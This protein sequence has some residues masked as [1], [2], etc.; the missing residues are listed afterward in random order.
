MKDIYL[1]L[2][3]WLKFQ[4]TV[5]TKDVLTAQLSTNLL[6]QKKRQIEE[7]LNAL[8]TNMVRRCLLTS[9]RLVSWD[10]P[11]LT[12]IYNRVGKYAGKQHWQQRPRHPSL[13]PSKHSTEYRNSCRGRGLLPDL[14][15]TCWTSYE[16]VLPASLR[17]RCHS[18]GN[19]TSFLAREISFNVFY[20]ILFLRRRKT[21]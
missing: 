2:L 19:E 8:Q 1:F 17:G 21:A 18:W 12:R 5:T 6:L 13:P 7:E 4:T 9:Y 3:F 20:P 16:N 10:R 14:F 11:E 15:S